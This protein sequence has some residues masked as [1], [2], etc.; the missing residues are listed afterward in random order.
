MGKVE[1]IMWSFLVLL[2]GGAQN[3]S[4]KE[5]VDIVQKVSD[6][7]GL[8]LFVTIFV[9]T[10]TLLMVYSTTRKPDINILEISGPMTEEEYNLIQE[11]M[12]YQAWLDN[13]AI[14]P[15]GALWRLPF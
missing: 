11:A 4:P 9:C 13:L 5:S 14:S 12:S 10:L 15:I 2:V 8:P 1:L 7:D 3:D 6:I